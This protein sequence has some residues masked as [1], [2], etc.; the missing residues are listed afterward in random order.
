MADMLIRGGLIV[1]GTGRSPYMADIL[2]E[3][4]RICAIGAFSDVDARQKI[5]ATGLVVS[6]G[7]IDGHTH[8]ELSL[9]RNRQHPSAVHQGITSLVTAQCGLGFAPLPREQWQ[10]S[11]RMNAGIFGGAQNLPRWDSFS[12]YLKQL[13]GCAVNVGSNAPHNAIRQMA[14]GFSDEPLRGEALDVAQQALDVA[15]HEGAL[16]F[17]VG[18]VYYPGAYADTLELIELCRVVKQHDAVF[19][20]HHRFAKAYSGVDPIEEI[21][22]VVRETG[23][24]LNMLHYK[25]NGWADISTILSP[26]EP[27]IEEG[28][29]VHFEFYPYL[30]GAGF[31]ISLFPG[32][33]QQGGPDRIMER[34]QDPSIRAKLLHDMAVRYPFVYP[35][36]NTCR[37]VYTRDPHSHDLGR[38]FAEIAKER[39]ETEAET[40]LR[41]L[42]EYELEIGFEAVETQSEPLK[43]K[44][45][46]DQCLLFQHPRYTIG[47]D[48]ISEGRL[49]H[50]RAWGTFPRVVRQM[51]DR[52]LPIEQ[53]LPKITSAPAQLYHLKDRG[54]IAQGMFAD[55]CLFDPKTIRDSATFES[56]RT[57]AEGIHHVLVNGIP[58]LTNGQLTGLLPGNALRRG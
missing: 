50:P 37:I 34:L 32:W 31:L 52:G 14:L 33:L 17:S 26:F 40:M 42:I 1:D 25:T 6:P 47:S 45:Y 3:R 35:D 38:T 46:D 30:V 9:M 19:C 56:P 12:S 21:V 41:L 29:D 23:V 16:G 48:T 43:Q 13:D 54:V 53:I 18:L 11:V 58:T 4:D 39:G 28:A 20:V 55:I 15:L 44:L 57:P 5:D 7:F 22:E 49:C 27:L 24:R 51:L 10:D 2:I 36:G 8:S